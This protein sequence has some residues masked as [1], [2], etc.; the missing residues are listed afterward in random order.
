PTNPTPTSVVAQVATSSTT[1]AVLPWLGH[2]TALRSWKQGGLGEVLVGRDEQLHRD[3]AFKRIRADRASDTDA[4]RRFE[5]EAEITAKREP[6]GIVPIY[7]LVQGSDGQPCYVMRFIHGDT[8]KAA[9]QRWHARSSEP[10]T[11]VSG[12]LPHGR[13]S[14]NPHPFDGL[15]FRALL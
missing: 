15:E 10:R 2:V 14:A 12:P 8:L 11:L 3:V 1:M 13:G 5:L 9:I 4:H 6:P 7:G